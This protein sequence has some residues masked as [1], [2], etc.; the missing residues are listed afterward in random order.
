MNKHQVECSNCGRPCHKAYAATH[1]GLCVYCAEP[2][3]RWLYRLPTPAKPR[4]EAIVSAKTAEKLAENR[5]RRLLKDEFTSKHL[6]CICHNCKSLAMGIGPA[7]GL[8][9]ES[10]YETLKMSQ[11]R[12][13]GKLQ[14]VTLDAIQ[15]FQHKV[16]QAVKVKPS[17]LVT[18]D[19]ENHNKT[20]ILRFLAEHKIFHRNREKWRLTK[21]IPGHINALDNLSGVLVATDGVLCVIETSAGKFIDNCHL[22][23]FVPDKIEPIVTE[24]GIELRTVSKAD[25]KAA[26][27]LELIQQVDI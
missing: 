5:R 3:K 19:A 7:A 13:D 10:H 4:P 20:A 26:E 17:L 8:L 22:H 18:T 27:M 25:R 16:A 23:W 6:A 11:P 24:D 15:A 1:G 14:P 2:G 21:R 12:V 9:C